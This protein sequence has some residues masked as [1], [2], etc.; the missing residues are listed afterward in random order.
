MKQ[1]YVEQLRKEMFIPVIRKREILKAKILSRA[2]K[3]KMDIHNGSNDVMVVSPL[4]KE[5]LINRKEVIN[6]YVYLN[7]RRVR[8]AGWK[9]S[10]QYMIARD[11]NT[12]AVALMMP[13][14][15]YIEIN[16]KK[17]GKG[18]YI[19]AY[20]DDQGNI[21]INSIGSIDKSLFRKMFYM[22]NN[23]MLYK[24]NGTKSVAKELDMN[25]KKGNMQSKKEVIQKEKPV[26]RI[27]NK[28]VVENKELKYSAIA[29]LVDNTDTLVGFMLKDNLGKYKSVS[30]KE[31]LILCNNG[32][33]DN[34]VV[35]TMSDTN[36]KYLRGN[37]IKI[38]SLPKKLI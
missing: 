29:R 3:E 10:R 5:E 2:E 15:Y 13:S 6:K 36:K 14:N 26:N 30:K 4:G 31:L 9:S 21:D 1:I 25:I 37:G 8:L 27:S 24:Y 20:L 33:V 7:D 32:I 35:A 17:I 34:I 19:I 16:N 18:K 12:P 11:D 38:D 22:P 28:P 23:E